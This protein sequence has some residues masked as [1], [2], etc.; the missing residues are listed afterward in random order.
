[1]TWV[2]L[3][4]LYRPDQFGLYGKRFRILKDKSQ[5]DGSK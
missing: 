1:M 3:T 4:M 2:E 5:K